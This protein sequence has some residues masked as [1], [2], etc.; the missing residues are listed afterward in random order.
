MQLRLA[1]TLSASGEAAPLAH[2]LDDILAQEPL[3]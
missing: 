3:S 1:L 2:V